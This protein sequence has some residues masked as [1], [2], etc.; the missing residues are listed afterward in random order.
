MGF[1]QIFDAKNANLDRILTLG[2]N[3]AHLFV[4][5]IVHKAI[6]TVDEEGTEAAAVTSKY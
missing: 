1:N 4:D 6:I 5:K 2:S 3:N